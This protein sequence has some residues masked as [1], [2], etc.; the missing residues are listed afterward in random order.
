M[1][2]QFSSHDETIYSI[3]FCFQT[4]YLSEAITVRIRHHCVFMEKTS[5]E[6]ID[7]YWIYLLLY[8]LEVFDFGTRNSPSQLLAINIIRRSKSLII[9]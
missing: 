5:K 8:R 4:L 1:F 2:S 3:F 9:Y 6:L 7:L